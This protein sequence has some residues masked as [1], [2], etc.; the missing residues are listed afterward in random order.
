MGCIGLG[1]LF[2]FSVSVIVFCFSRAF[3]GVYVLFAG[4]VVC[5]AVLGIFM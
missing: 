5:C 3:R 1:F 2:L 4:F